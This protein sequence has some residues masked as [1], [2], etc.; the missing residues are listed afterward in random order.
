MFKE[1][2]FNNGKNTT[3][4]IIC[5][6]GSSYSYGGY[7]LDSE[8]NIQPQIENPNYNEDD[9]IKLNLEMEEWIKNQPRLKGDPVAIKMCPDGQYWGGSYQ[10]GCL[11]NPIDETKVLL[12]FFPRTDIATSSMVTKAPQEETI[13]GNGLTNGQKWAWVV[14]LTLAAWGLI[15]WSQKQSNK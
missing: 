9:A 4:Q 13:L 7:C 8:G 6:E 5:S 1:K 12:D 11:D 15:Y 14:G 10:V 2:Y 3:D